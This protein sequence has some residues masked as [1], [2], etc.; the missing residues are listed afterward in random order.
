MRKG[1]HNIA[2]RAMTKLKQKIHNEDNVIS[3]TDP[4]FDLV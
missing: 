4:C 3:Q 2:G 1:E